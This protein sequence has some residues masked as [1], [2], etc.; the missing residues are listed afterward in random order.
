MVVIEGERG[1]EA[2]EVNGEADDRED[3]SQTP[4]PKP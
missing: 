4:N 1:A 2:V 3:K